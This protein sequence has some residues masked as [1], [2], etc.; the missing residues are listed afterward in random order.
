MF[1]I[2]GELTLLVFLFLQ[3][4]TQKRQRLGAFCF[5]E[6]CLSLLFISPVPHDNY[7]NDSEFSV[8]I[9]CPK[10]L[11]VSPLKGGIA[12]KGQQNIAQGT[13]LGSRTLP[14]TI[15]CSALKGQQNIR[16]ATP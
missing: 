10:Y 1:V 7:A 15:N 3:R 16:R 12:P 13:A 4:L 11:Y 9:K 14:P 8:L 6:S 5:Y 2:C